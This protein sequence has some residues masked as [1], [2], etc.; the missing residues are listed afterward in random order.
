MITKISSIFLETVG[1]EIP[2]NDDIAYNDDIRFA[3]QI[4]IPIKYSRCEDSFCCGEF[5]S[6]EEN[7]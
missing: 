7:Y 4:V 1:R 2:Q 6:F 3:M 5:P